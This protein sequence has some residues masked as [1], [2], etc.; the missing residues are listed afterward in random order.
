MHDKILGHMIFPYDC[1][2]CMTESSV[3]ILY[4]Q[5]AIS[6]NIFVSFDDTISDSLDDTADGRGFLL[7]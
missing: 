3:L 4:V 6:D 2:S 5:S 1:I 7:G